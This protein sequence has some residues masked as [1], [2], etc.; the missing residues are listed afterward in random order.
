MDPTQFTLNP[1]QPMDP[2]AQAEFH[3]EVVARNEQRHRARIAAANR[4]A[5][6]AQPQPGDVLF[7]TPAR[8]IKQRGRAGVRFSDAKRERVFVVEPG[9]VGTVVQPDSLVVDVYGAEE[10]LAD[11]SLNTHAT[12]A[13][14]ADASAERAARERAEAELARVNRENATLRAQMA[15][16]R[17]NAPDPGDGTPGRLKAARAAAAKAGKPSDDGFESGGG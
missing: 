13:V 17:R 7:V 2:E 16:A 14:D 10:I 11:M 3:A 8:G 5:G 6:I 12:S 4:K 9:A 1:L 15:E